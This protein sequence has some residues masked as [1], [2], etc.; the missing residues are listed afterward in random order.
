MK[1]ERSYSVDTV[2]VLVLF[3]VFAATILFVLMSGA[4]VYK[5]TARIM[6]E[7]YEERTCLSY[8]SQK[9]RHCDSDNAVYITEFDGTPALAL[10]DEINNKEYNT[11]I[12]FYDGHVKE[13]FCEKGA[14]F[15]KESGTDIIEAKNLQ[16]ANVDKDSGL[17]K[18]KC[19][20]TN[21]DSS[22]III[23]TMSENGG[24][25]NE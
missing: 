6:Q 8:I 19:T 5:E 22:T 16:F 13:L 10:E 25:D 24:A 11:L 4:N 20:G 15:S 21:G 23:G 9:V 14:A 18:I 2:F 1:K 17:I 12:Y 3:C 7:R